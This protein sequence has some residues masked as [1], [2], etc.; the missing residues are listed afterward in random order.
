MARIVPLRIQVP[1]SDSVTTATVKAKAQ[2]AL[3]ALGLEI[4]EDAAGEADDLL[5]RP[6]INW[7]GVDVLQGVETR[8]PNAKKTRGAT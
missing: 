2:T 6:R 8:T 4:L 1:A 7:D 5:N 3:R